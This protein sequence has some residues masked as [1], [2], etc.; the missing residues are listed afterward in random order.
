MS[1]TSKCYVTAADYARYWEAAT[2]VGVD[3][4]NGPDVTVYRCSCGFRCS[5][6]AEMHEHVD[7]H[8]EGEG[9]RGEP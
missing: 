8:H 1:P 5:S 9:E 3:L 2:I 7:Q 6:A 4:A